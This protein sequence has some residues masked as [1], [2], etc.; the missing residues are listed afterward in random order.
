MKFFGPDLYQDRNDKNDP[1]DPRADK[2]AGALRLGG[3]FA[4]PRH[5]YGVAR[6][7]AERCREDLNNPE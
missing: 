1:E 3:R 7:F 2:V 6:G 5:G 4:E